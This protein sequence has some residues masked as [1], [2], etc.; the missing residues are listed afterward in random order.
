MQR[1]RFRLAFNRTSRRKL[2]HRTV[3]ATRSSHSLRT[4]RSALD[5]YETTF[6]FSTS[7][8]EARRCYAAP[9]APQAGKQFREEEWGRVV[10]RPV[11][12]MLGSCG[13]FSG[14]I[15]AN[16]RV[17]PS[18]PMWVFARWIEHLPDVAIDRLQHSD[19]REFDRAALFG[20]LR[21]KLRGRQDLRHIVFGFRNDLAEV[22]DGLAQRA[23][24]LPSSS[25]IGS[26]NRRDQDTTPTPQLKPASGAAG[27][28][29]FPPAEGL[30]TGP[31]Q[32]QTC[33]DCHKENARP[34]R[35]DPQES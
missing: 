28:D 12:S 9:P 32:Q 26:E 11:P 35:S 8:A 30:E 5:G 21:Q 33:T 7:N 6:Y 34:I 27:G 16:L 1:Q 24:L 17:S 18:S 19:A 29:S 2:P 15:S 10:E 14:V 23:S 25:T 3:S 22:R 31:R 4:K 20:R 13:R